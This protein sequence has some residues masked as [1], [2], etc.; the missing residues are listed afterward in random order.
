MNRLLLF[1]IFLIGAVAQQP[2]ALA[3]EDSLQSLLEEVRKSRQVQQ[4]RDQ[5]REKRFLEQHQQRKSELEA[6]RQQL[7]AEQQ[8]QQQLL[9]QFDDQREELEKLKQTHQQSTGS[10]GELFGVVRQVASES[11]NLFKNDLTSSRQQ[12][13]LAILEEVASSR[14]LPSLE[15]LQDLWEI[16]L[17]RIIQ[18]GQIWQASLPVILTSGEEQQEQVTVVGLFNALSNGRYLRYLPETARFVELSRQPAPRYQL[19]A[20]QAEQSDGGLQKLA[21]DPSR[22]AI[23]SLLVA[24]PTLTERI[25]QGGYIG[26]FILFLGALG[27]LVIIERVISL[28]WVGRRVKRQLKQEEP[29]ENNPLGRLLAINRQ[30]HAISGDALQKHFDEAILRELP[31]LR[32]GLRLLAIF[33]AVAPLL[34]L[35]GTVTGMIETFQ[36]ITLFGTGDPK[37]MSGGISQALVTT[38]LGLAVAIPMVLLHSYLAG[39]SNRVIRLLDQQSAAMVAARTGS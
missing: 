23:L 14:S 35:L 3:A 2:M 1:I 6:I 12:Q 15:R 24:S 30:H 16:F 31:K 5:A 17:T 38:E 39:R 8:R 33:A 32:R 29:M 20:K 13:D 28:F 37:L 7:Q 19:L 34:G 11:L 4:S 25:Q 10:F 18:S 22:G 26:Y 27:S 36:S 9:V 21:I